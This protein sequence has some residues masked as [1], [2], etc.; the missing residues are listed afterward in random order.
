MLESGIMRLLTEENFLKLVQDPV[1][2]AVLTPLPHFTPRVLVPD[3]HYVVMDLPFY[4]EARTADAKKMADQLAQREK[5]H[6]EGILR[7]APGGS[8]S[9]TNSTTRPS[10]KKKSVPW[11]VKKALDLSPPSSSPSSPSTSIKVGADQ[12]SSS[13]PSMGD[14]SDQE[15]KPIVTFIDLEPEEEEE[16]E[17]MALNLRVGF[18]ERQCKCLFEALPTIPPPVKKIRLEAPR[19]EPV[20]DVSLEQVPPSKTDRP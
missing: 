5:K 13:S 12:G 6:Q 8:H 7:Q 14:N 19:V 17:D 9:A 18:K 1:S 2:Y 10:P 15:P 16:A 11:P 20:L 3:E 4:E